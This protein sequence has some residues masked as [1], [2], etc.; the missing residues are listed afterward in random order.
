MR[1]VDL[2]TAPTS[3]DRRWGEELWRGAVKRKSRF[4]NS[5]TKSLTETEEGVRV[6][7]SLP[8]EI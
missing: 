7:L 8:K 2:L 1:K 5:P 4:K 3:K 6:S